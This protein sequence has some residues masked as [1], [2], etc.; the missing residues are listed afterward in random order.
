MLYVGTT[1][2]TIYVLSCLGLLIGT[3]RNRH[4]FFIPWMVVDFFGTLI[5]ASVM[6]AVGY[7]KVAY[8]GIGQWQYC[9]FIRW[10]IPY[11]SV[12]QKNAHV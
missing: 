6:I 8:Y 7:N 3:L 1:L 11:L 10:V 2:A 4:E 5:S 12:Y 9:E